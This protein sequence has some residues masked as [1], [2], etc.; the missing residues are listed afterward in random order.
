[1]ALDGEVDAAT[2]AE[3]GKL[4]GAQYLVA[5]AVTKFE[6][7]TKG[8]GIGGLV[9]KK[10][11]GGAALYESE[12][13]ITLRIINSTTGEIIASENIKK[14]E[15]SVGL[16]AATVLFGRPIAGGLFKSASMQTA[17][18][19]AIKEA[20]TVIGTKIPSEPGGSDSNFIKLVVSGV[21]FTTL[22]KF[23]ALLKGIEGVDNV[24]KRLSKG[25]GTIQLDYTGTAEDLAEAIDSARGGKLDF[26]ITGLSESEIDV[27]MR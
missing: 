2:G 16:A 10:V 1:M 5:G 8:G 9:S 7:K 6:E 13:G 11:L 21:T 17:L 24:Q 27:E 22:K 25:V 4:I 15:R 18:E 14:K 3:F 12:L 26:E 19:K 23:T 20:V